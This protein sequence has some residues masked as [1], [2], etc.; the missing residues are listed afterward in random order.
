MARTRNPDAPVKEKPVKTDCFQDQ[1]FDAAVKQFGSAVSGWDDFLK[2]TYGVP[3]HN[4]L[5]LQYLVGVDVI[6]L[7]RM[8]NVVGP[9]GV[10]KSSFSWYLATLFMRFSGM[11]M[12]LDS[13]G[14]SNESQTRA[15]VST[16]LEMEKMHN[17]WFHHDKAT[18]LDQLL[19]FNVWYIKQV[20]EMGGKAI[21]T[22]IMLLNDSLGAITSEEAVE[23]RMNDE[24]IKGFSAARNA[25]KLKEDIQVFASVL[26]NTPITGLYINHQK[27]VVDQNGGR[28]SYLP[29]LKSETGG[30]HQRFQYTWI[31]ELNQI[32]TDKGIENQI[33]VFKI[34]TKKNAT[35]PK[36]D[37]GIEVPYERLWRGE[38]VEGNELLWYDW[39][40]SLAMLLTDDKIMDLAE[41][42][43]VFDITCKGNRYSSK[44][45]GLDKVMDREMGAAIHAN[46]ELVKR[47]QDTVLQIRRKPTYGKLIDGIDRG[48]PGVELL[49]APAGSDGQEMS[50]SPEQAP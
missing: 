30:E 29:A 26:R 27:K 2:S 42:A 22:P 9:W 23:G 20:S 25:S 49:A 19:D 40:A 34:T 13:E 45:L 6:P 7:G 37:K 33:P 36:R 35:G 3:I 15:M 5:P 47:L 1:L 31:L 39:N 21:N 32:R 41:V 17:K 48:N 8:I 4:N 46:P 18:T 28:A 43:K 50:G 38:Q 12:F 44:E 10:T 24:D 16:Y 14:K 11:V